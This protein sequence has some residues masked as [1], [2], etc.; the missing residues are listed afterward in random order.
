MR[1]KQ[2]IIIYFCG[3]KG[4]VSVIAAAREFQLLAENPFK[5]SFIA[6]PAVAGDALILRST[7]DLYCI[8]E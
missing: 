5:A 7:A 1:A 2:L 6:S 4:V 3:K 8:A